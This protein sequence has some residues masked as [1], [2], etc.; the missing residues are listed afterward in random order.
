MNMI[1]KSL[2]SKKNIYYDRFSVS[3]DYIYQFARTTFIGQSN[4]FTPQYII[5]IYSKSEIYM[6]N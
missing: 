2:K 4:H 6:Y 1:Y 3:E 5:Y